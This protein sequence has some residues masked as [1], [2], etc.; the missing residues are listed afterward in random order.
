MVHTRLPG[1]CTLLW[2]P[3]LWKY[4]DSITTFPGKFDVIVIDGPARGLTRLRCAERA[5]ER[6]QPGGLIILDNADWLPKSARLLREK[7]LLQVD[8][9]GFLPIAGYTETTSLFF[10]RECRLRPLAER[11]P[12]PS[13]AADKKNWEENFEEQRIGEV[14]RW[15]GGVI[16]NVERIAR[17]TKQSPEGVRTFELLF[18]QPSP[19]NVEWCLFDLDRQRMLDGA[20]PLRGAT[21]E[22][23]VASI[24]AMTWDEFCELVRRSPM[25][26]YLIGAQ[27]AHGAP[28]V[29]AVPRQ[30]Q[31][32]SASSGVAGATTE[33]R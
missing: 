30:Y 5:V 26:R 22:D 10:D 13:A 14:Y 12:M 3:D 4:A 6:L 15:N 23:H 17:L 27:D 25:R 20:R 29:A 9:S 31:Q 8:M 19:G 11:Q 2:E 21:P 1:N 33:S 16:L 32:P 28:D 7:G 24:D 18:K